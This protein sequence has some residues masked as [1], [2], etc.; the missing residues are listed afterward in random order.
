MNIYYAREQLRSCSIYDL[1]MNV[2][3]YARVSTEKI[4]QQV[5]IKHQE[6]HFEELI[7]NNHQWFLAG[8]ILTMV[9]Q[10]SIRK[11]EKSFNGCCEML[12]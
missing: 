3:Y 10:E 2:A 4:E 12:S 7:R 11:S 6:E 1:K 5:S 9:F 8:A